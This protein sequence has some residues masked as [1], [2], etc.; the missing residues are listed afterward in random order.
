MPP[1]GYA[2]FLAPWFYP[3]VLP[4][5]FPCSSRFVASDMIALL[6]TVRFFL[7]PNL[8]ASY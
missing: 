4:S 2:L 8:S 6:L 7:Q 3:M 5:L 1:I